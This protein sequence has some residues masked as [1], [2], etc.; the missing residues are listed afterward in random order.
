MN[1]KQFKQDLLDSLYEPYKNCNLC[2]L[3]KAG[4]T[5]VVFGRGSADASLLFLGEGPGKDE[6]LEALPFVGRSGKLLSKVLK[7]LEIEESQVYIANIV[8]CRPPNN[9]APLPAEINTCTQALL[10]KQL[11]IISPKIICTLGSSALKTFINT[12]QGITKIRG[13]VLPYKKTA[14]VPTYHP[15]YIL[16]NKSKLQTFADDIKKAYSLSIKTQ[17]EF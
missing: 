10:N 9:R 1:K 11:E 2:P 17:I 3:A 6:D 16:R 12:P 5:N 8:K 13:T 7:S 4:R 15:A 14:L